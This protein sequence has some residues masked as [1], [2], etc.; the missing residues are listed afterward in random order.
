[1]ERRK[2]S[3]TENGEN[4]TMENIDKNINEKVI[5]SCCDQRCPSGDLHCSKGKEHFGIAVDN[6]DRER[7]RGGRHRGKH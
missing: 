7:A 4:K 1:M 6:K 3:E 2:K 5:C